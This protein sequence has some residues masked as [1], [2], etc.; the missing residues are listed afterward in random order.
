MI[1]KTCTTT[2]TIAIS[3]ITALIWNVFL[4]QPMQFTTVTPIVKTEE[5]MRAANLN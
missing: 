2:A 5:I 3:A 4:D 1:A